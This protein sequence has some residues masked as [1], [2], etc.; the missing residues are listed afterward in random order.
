M[1]TTNLLK[2]AAV[3]L[4]GISLNGTV[5]ADNDKYS[6]YTRPA[7]GQITNSIM[8]IAD[9]IRQ[10]QKPSEQAVEDW[11][12]EGDYLSEES[13]GAVEFW[14]LETDYLDQE[15]QPLESWMF[16]E[17]RLDGTEPASSVE[18]WMTETNYL[19]K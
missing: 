2:I 8:L 6:R 13:A 4:L 12:F 15:V 7:Y 5:Q 9:D 19:S 10:M 16:N 3:I 11:M 1:K 14:M 18:P 17:S